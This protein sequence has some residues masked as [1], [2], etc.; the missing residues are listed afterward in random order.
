MEPKNQE[1]GKRT[2]DYDGLMPRFKYNGHLT[3]PMSFS[4]WRHIGRGALGFTNAFNCLHVNHIS[5]TPDL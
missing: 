4:N 3:H 5:Q 1:A 2:V